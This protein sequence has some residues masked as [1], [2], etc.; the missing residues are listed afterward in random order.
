MSLFLPLYYS[1]RRTVY[2]LPPALKN[3]ENF[4]IPCKKTLLIISRAF[5]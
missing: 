5:C 3:I 1:Y 4:L 2:F